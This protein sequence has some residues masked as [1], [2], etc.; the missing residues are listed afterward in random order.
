MT[1]NASATKAPWVDPDDAPELDDEF[2]ERAEVRKG[3]QVVRRGRP[4]GG[5]KDSITLRLDRDVA[6]ALRASGPGWQTRLN[7]LLRSVLALT[8]PRQ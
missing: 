2:F 6:A 4:P 5:S 3:G 7:E 8:T 1:A